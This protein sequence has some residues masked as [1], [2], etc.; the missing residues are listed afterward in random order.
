LGKEDLTG[1][2][3]GVTIYISTDFWFS[4]LKETTGYPQGILTL[5]Q[6]FRLIH[7]I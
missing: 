3:V 6:D 1:K 7:R 2:G 5:N 4:S